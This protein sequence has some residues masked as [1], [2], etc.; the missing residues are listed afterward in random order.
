VPSPVR[1]R[2]A[3]ATRAASPTSCSTSSIPGSRRAPSASSAAPRPPAAPAP[4]RPAPPRRDGPPARPP[5]GERAV[6]QRHVLTG[7]A[8]LRPEGGGGAVEAEQRAVHVGGCHQVDRCQSRV[9]RTA[10]PVHV[11]QRGAAGRE[12]LACRVQPLHPQRRQQSGA[13][14]VGGAAPEADDHPGRSQVEGLTDQLADPVGGGR[15]GVALGLGE[16]VQA[17]GCGRLHVRRR[18]VHQDSRL[19]RPGQRVLHGCR[20]PDGLWQRGPEHLQEP[21]P[22]VRQRREVQLVVR[23][24]RPPARGERSCGLRPG[25]SAAEAVRSDQYAHVH[26]LA[27]PAPTPAVDVPA[28]TR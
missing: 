18:A 20:V 23:R 11:A 19:H 6:E 5:I 2:S 12:P 3:S 15:P 25:Q 26:T 1:T 21:G 17:A 16:Q 28:R 24:D 9:R 22:A 14:V 13:T 7:R 27:P 8:L 4:G 10:E